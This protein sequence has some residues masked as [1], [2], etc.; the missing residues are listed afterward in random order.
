MG[1]YWN[2]KRVVVPGGAGFIGSHVVDLLV[3]AGAQVSVIDDL[4]SGCWSRIEGHGGRIARHE[5]DLVT[6]DLAECFEGADAVLNLAGLAPGLTL[7]SS[8]HEVLYQGN[9]RIADAVLNGV[10][11]AGVGRYL[12]VSSSCVYPDDA[13]VPTGEVSFDGKGPEEVNRGYGNAKR[14]V[15]RRAIEAAAGG[16]RFELAIARPFN[17]F[18]ARD[19]AT[20]AGAH[21]IPS[22][23]ERILDASPEIVVWGSGRQTRSFIHAADLAMGMLLAAEFCVDSNPVNIGS[24]EEISMKDLVDVLQELAGTDKPVRFD[25]SKPEG[26]ARKACD[27]SRLERMTGFRQRISL[28]QGLEEMVRARLVPS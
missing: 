14:E 24:N 20:G 12:E 10:L 5:V 7:E 2:E 26:A 13:P 25:R 1:C 4:S 19:M 15:E 17:A 28:R 21:V 3:E 16:S 8:R 23:L 9:L 11:A 27:A 18:G 22:L 6:A